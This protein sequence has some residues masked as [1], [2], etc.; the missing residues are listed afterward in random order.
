M[1]LNGWMW[2]KTFQ[3]PTFHLW[4]LDQENY[5]EQFIEMEAVSFCFKHIFVDAMIALN[6]YE[7]KYYAGLKNVSRELTLD[8]MIRFQGRSE[9]LLK[10]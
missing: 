8:E 1:K 3:S 7:S 4:S 6:V 5:Q 10:K 9:Q 2:T